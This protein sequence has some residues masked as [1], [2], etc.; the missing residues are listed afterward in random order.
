MVR[1]LNP[2]LPHLTEEL[3]QQLGHE[4]PLVE[5]PWPKAD[6]ALLTDDSVTLAIQIN[7]KLRGTITLPRD[8]S[9]KTC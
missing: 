9:A 1:I 6:P 7:G 3:W 8:A 4:T 5:M 2:M